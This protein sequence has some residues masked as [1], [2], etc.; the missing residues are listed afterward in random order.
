MP[1]PSPFLIK[2]LFWQETQ[3][4]S[5]QLISGATGWRTPGSGRKLIVLLLMPL[6]LAISSGGTLMRITKKLKALV[7]RETEQNSN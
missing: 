6:N 4:G 5:S 7:T 1:P 3:L 2:F